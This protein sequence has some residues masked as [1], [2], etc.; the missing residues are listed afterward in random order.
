VWGSGYS[1][2]LEVVV[3]RL[4]VLAL[5]ACATSDSAPAAT[6]GPGDPARGRVVYATQC[7]ACHNTDPAVAGALGPEVKG[8]SR[9]LIEARVL[10]ASYPPGYTPKRTTTQMVPMPHLATNIDDLVAYLAPD[11]GK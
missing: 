1:G 11:P 7:T 6:G 2:G 8:A 5:S 9:E 10:R 3:V 4:A